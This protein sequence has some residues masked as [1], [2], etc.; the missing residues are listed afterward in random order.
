MEILKFENS[1]EGRPPRDSKWSL[2]MKATFGVGLLA[3]TFGIGSTLAANI[4]LNGGDSIEFGQGV[5]ITAACDN[6]ITV[7]PLS[8]FMNE[9]AGSFVMNEI[10]ITNIDLTPEGW[11]VDARDWADGWNEDEQVWD[12]GYEDNAGKYLGAGDVWTNTC[13]GK[14]LLIRAYTDNSEYRFA[15]TDYST[16]SPLYLNGPYDE[17]YDGSTCNTR[18]ANAGIGFYV[19]TTVGM[20]NT[21]DITFESAKLADDGDYDCTVGGDLSYLDDGYFEISWGGFVGSSST[22]LL[23]LDESDGIPVDSRWVSKLTIESVNEAPTSWITTA[24]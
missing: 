4:S 12:S 9:G 15:T 1:N 18:P 2:K 19:N 20:P 6:E 22:A 13:D 14:T 21:N 11:D 16:N 23:V 8:T 10:Q 7:T 17:A 5:A 3:A 24:G